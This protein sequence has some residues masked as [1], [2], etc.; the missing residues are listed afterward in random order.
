MNTAAY[1][2]S[3][4]KQLKDEGKGLAE[5]AWKTA[6]ACV[7]WAYVFGARGQYCTPANRRARYNSTPNGKDKDNIKDKCKN[8]NSTTYCNGCQWFPDNQMTRFFDCRGFTFWVLYAVYGWKLNGAGCTSQWN[9]NDNW[10]AKGTIADGMPKDTLVCLFYPSKTKANTMEHTGFG[11]NDETVECSGT[12]YYK[13]KRDK[14]WTH[15]AIPKCVDGGVPVGKPTLRKGSTGPYV[16]ECQTDLIQLGDDLSPYGADGKYG[17]KTVAAV[18][19]FQ[20]AH[21]LTADGVCGPMTWNALDAAVGPTQLYTVIIP[22]LTLDQA[23][24]LQQQ[25]PDAEKRA[26]GSEAE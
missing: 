1:V 23:N 11:L 10:K 14:K 26:E 15:W 22:H 24:A 5:V 21:G 25:Y 18:K 7:G 12:V 13:S 2:D 3:Y 6:L 4:I 8:F 16:V 9:D 17:N 20:Q 19:S